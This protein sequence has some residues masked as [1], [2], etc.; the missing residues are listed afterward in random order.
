MNF[1]VKKAQLQTVLYVHNGK[2]KCSAEAEH[3]FLRFYFT[4]RRNTREITV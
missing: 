4:S 1:D 2:E 3:V